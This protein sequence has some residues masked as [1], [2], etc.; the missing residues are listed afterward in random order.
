MKGGKKIMRQLNKMNKKGQVG[1]IPGVVMTIVLIGAFLG[2][3]FLI[4]EEFLD[5][6]EDIAEA[7]I[8]ATSYQGIND[9][10]EAL[11]TV[12]DLLGLIVLVLVVGIIIAVLLGVFPTGG[13]VSAA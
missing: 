1:N 9:T 13:R 10:I 11:T 4:L 12:P 7:G 3:G 8:K 5:Q 6:T 2:V